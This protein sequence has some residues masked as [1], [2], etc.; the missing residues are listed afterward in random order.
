MM[1]PAQLTCLTPEDSPLQLWRC[2]SGVFALHCYL[3]WHTKTQQAVMIDAG[4]DLSGLLALVDTHQLQLTH[5]VFTHAHVDHVEGWAMVQQAVPTIKLW[6]H[7]DADFWLDNLQAQARKYGLP[8]PPK[9]QWHQC[10]KHNQT[11]MF[12]GFTMVA[13]HAPGHA[14]ESLCFV[15]PDLNAVIVGDVIFY[16]SIGRTDFPRGDAATLEAAIKAQIYTLP[17]DMVIYSGHGPATTVGAEM[18]HNPYVRP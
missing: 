3:L 11:L 9:P 15:I 10:I 6:G 18:I 8:V 1:P 7:A 16:R 17:H 2:T 14:P 12:N 4:A 13:R 5:L